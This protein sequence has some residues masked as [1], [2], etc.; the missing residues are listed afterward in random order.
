[1]LG[2]KFRVTVSALEE[3]SGECQSYGHRFWKND[4][5]HSVDLET[6]HR[7]SK[8]FDQQG[9]PQE[10]SED[11]LSFPNSLF[12]HQEYLPEFI[13]VHV[14]GIKMKDHLQVAL[15]EKSRNC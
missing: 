6:F 3:K 4:Q 11:Q 12:G 2:G 15:G 5:I 7:I 9:A 8:H 10:M 13:A 14:A 1:M